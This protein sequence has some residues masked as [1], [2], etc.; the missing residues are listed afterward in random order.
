MKKLTAAQTK[1]ITN[2][3]DQ[4]KAAA[5]VM[6]ETPLELIKCILLKHE[7]AVIEV[8]KELHDEKMRLQQQRDELK[9]DAER[10]QWLR[11]YSGGPPGAL[12]VRGEW[13]GYLGD[14]VQVRADALDTAI[15]AAIAK[16][17]P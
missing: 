4:V 11:D 12:T 14:F 7:T 1:S 15:D 8:M 13:N 16:V 2:A 10:Y 6:I 17:K 3:K 5:N 9:K